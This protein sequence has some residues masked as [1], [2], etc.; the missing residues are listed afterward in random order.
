M[1]KLY[2]AAVKVGTYEKNGETKN[3]Y[4][5]V[6]VVLKGDK[7]PYLLLDR[8]FNPAGVPNPDGKESVLVSFFEPKEQKD[9]GKQVSTGG[10]GATR[11]D[12]NDDI[13]FAHQFGV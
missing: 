1:T 6:G 10:G 5:N 12:V 9:E 11:S 13:P 4:K 3:K 8:T 7:G 2:D